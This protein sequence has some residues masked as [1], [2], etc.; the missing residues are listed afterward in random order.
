[1]N[2][3]EVWPTPGLERNLKESGRYGVRVG[4]TRR[5]SETLEGQNFSGPIDPTVDI[6]FFQVQPVKWESTERF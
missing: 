1:M 6:G 4:I 2:Q 3:K 5:R